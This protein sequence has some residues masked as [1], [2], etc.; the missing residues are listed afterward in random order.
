MKNRQMG[1]EQRE[2]RSENKKFWCHW[3]FLH[4]KQHVYLTVANNCFHEKIVQFTF[5]LIMLP[6]SKSEAWIF[7]HWLFSHILTAMRFTVGLG[8]GKRAVAD[9][10][11][12]FSINHEK[13]YFI[14]FVHSS[15]YLS[16][17]DLYISVSSPGAQW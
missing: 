14:V 1:Y 5:L 12:D 6:M 8:Q 15:A 2:T 13:E 10:F 16:K 11:P 9:R 7:L 4:L 17:E 3:T